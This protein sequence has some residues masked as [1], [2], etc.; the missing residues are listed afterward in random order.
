MNCK[1]QLLIVEMVVSS[2]F[3]FF[4]FSVCM[5]IFLHWLKQTPERLALVLPGSK[6]TSLYS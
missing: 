2:G 3:A 4:V 6:T 5:C 1:V